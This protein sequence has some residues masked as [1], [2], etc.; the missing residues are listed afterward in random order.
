MRVCLGTGGEY[1]PHGFS[2]P[3]GGAAT[4]VDFAID[5]GK[6]LKS[7]TIRTLSN[8]VVIGLMSVTLER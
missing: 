1:F 2:R 7:M 3:R 6:L 5:P 8:T 4:V